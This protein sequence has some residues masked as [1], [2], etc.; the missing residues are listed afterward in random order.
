MQLL[1]YRIEQLRFANNPIDEI[2][3]IKNEMLEIEKEQMQHWFRLG[4]H[5]VEGSLWK[6]SDKF[7][8]HFTEKY[9]GNS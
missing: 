7:Q 1:F 5:L 6:P 2:I 3:E 4:M 8:E 9:K